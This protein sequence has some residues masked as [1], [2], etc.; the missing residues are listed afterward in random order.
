M[1]SS[2]G[3]SATKAS[4]TGASMRSSPATWLISARTASRP[5]TWLMRAAWALSRISVSVRARAEP[6]SPHSSGGSGRSTPTRGAE[7]SITSWLRRRSCS[8]SYASVSNPAS[9][10]RTKAF[11]SASTAS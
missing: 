3:S 5:S 11:I 1:R 8:C 4:R 6:H 7:R 9:G 10:R 2:A